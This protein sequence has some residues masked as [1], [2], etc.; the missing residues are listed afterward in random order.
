MIC[1][2][3]LGRTSELVVIK[4]SGI[5]LYRTTVPVI[6]ICSLLTLAV[7]VGENS[8][9][10]RAYAR[11]DAL[12]FYIKQGRFPQHV[13]LAPAASSWIMSVDSWD[14]TNL[15]APAAYRM[16]HFRRFD[17]RAQRLDFPLV[18]EIDPLTFAPRT[19]IEARSAHWDSAARHWIFSDGLRWVF[20][21]S[22][23]TSQESFSSLALRLPERPEY[24]AQEPLKA[25]AM[26]ISQLTRYIH[27]L[28]R[29]GSDTTELEVTL[30]RKMALAVACLVMGLF[31]IPFGIATGRHGALHAV[32]LGIGIG[33]TY[34]LLVDIF[35]QMG[36]YG[37]FSPAVAAWAPC[38]LL[39]AGGLYAL[40]RLRS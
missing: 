40:F 6:T 25:D 24:F 8:F 31:G 21:G 5:S 1:F 32:G 37:Y 4:A 13:E 12:R 11:Q 15:A 18:V 30:H 39:G 10:P 36:K 29:T 33:S 38:G 22:R 7:L 3:L 34:W 19:R 27:Y 23:V 26:T 20:E 17:R 35:S 14:Q 2:S 9:L 28:A 16:Y